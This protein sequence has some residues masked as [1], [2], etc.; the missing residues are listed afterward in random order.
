MLLAEIKIVIPY[1]P[2]GFNYKQF[3][4]Q[5]RPL[6]QKRFAQVFGG[7][8]TAETVV[9]AGSVVTLLAIIGTL[10]T[11][12]AGASTMLAN[13]AHARENVPVIWDDI[14]QAVAW[15]SV[16][17][18]DRAGGFPQRG[19]TVE[20]HAPVPTGLFAVGRAMDQLSADLLQQALPPQEAV[21]RAA[22][23]ADQLMQLR[24]LAPEPVDADALLCGLSR[25][26][27]VLRQVSTTDPV[28]RNANVFAVVEKAVL[29][30]PRGLPEHPTGPRRTLRL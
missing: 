9:G 24:E 21:E 28:Y 16:E 8:V 17:M 12:A 30:L 14:K 22:H 15:L 19:T 3:A 11:I 7:D 10:T 25:S 18:Q 6:A 26:V 4:E 20:I 5:V 1:N 29:D 13:Y 23:I 2:P 27:E